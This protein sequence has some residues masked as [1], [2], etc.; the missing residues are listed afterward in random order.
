M[1]C[2]QFAYYLLSTLTSTLLSTTRLLPWWRR[3]WLVFQMRG[4]S[5]EVGSG[6]M[7]VRRKEGGIWWWGIGGERGSNRRSLVVV[8]GIEMCEQSLRLLLEGS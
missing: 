7:K 8:G 2:N 4:Q 1:L 6:G 3:W 5:I